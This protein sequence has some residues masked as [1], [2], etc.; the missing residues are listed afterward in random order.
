MEVAKFFKKV[1]DE[2]DLPEATR[3]ELIAAVGLGSGRVSAL[4]RA[5][6]DEP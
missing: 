5:F 2:V 1:L 6:E 4:R 3:V